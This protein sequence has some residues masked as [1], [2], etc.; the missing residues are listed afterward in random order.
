VFQE[1]AHAGHGLMLVAGTGFD[2]EAQGRGVRL[3]VALGDDFEPV[4][5]RFGDEL[6]MD[7]RVQ[8]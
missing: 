8:I 6:H 1:M 7:F 5:K 3:V 2:K 4:G